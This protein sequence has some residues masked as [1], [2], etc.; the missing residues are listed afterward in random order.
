M[1]RPLYAT[2]APDGR[3]QRWDRPFDPADEKQLAKFIGF[4]SGGDGETTN[5]AGSLWEYLFASA[6]GGLFTLVMHCTYPCWWRSKSAH[7]W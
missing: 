3:I 4:L 7:F 5:S 6:L 2:V 1:N